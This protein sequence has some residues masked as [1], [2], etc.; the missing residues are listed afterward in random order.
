MIK[1]ISLNIKYFLNYILKYNLIYF[2]YVYKLK[3]LKKLSNIELDN[4]KIKKIKKLLYKSKKSK[5]YSK[6][7]SHIDIDSI[8][9]LNDL[10][11]LPIVT[12]EMIKGKEESLLT[13]PK[14]FLFKGF[15][16]GSTGSPL[17]VY[18]D[19]LSV[20]RENATVWLYR[21]EKGLKFKQPV[22]SLRGNLKKGEVFSFDRFTNTLYLSSYELN[23]KN[24]KLYYELINSFKPKAILAYPS[25]IY[26]LVTLLKE[27]SYEINVDLVFTSSETLYSY[28]RFFVEKNLSTTIYD[29]Y[30]NAERTVAFQQ[31]KNGYY[32]EPVCYSYCEFEKNRLITTSLNNFSFPLIR[33]KVDDIIEV[34]NLSEITQIIGREDDVVELQDGTKIGRLDHIFKGVDGIKY[35]QIIQNNLHYIDINIVEN[36]FNNDSLALLETKIQERLG[37]G[38]EYNIKM[39]NE[40]EIKYMK[41]GKFKMVINN[42]QK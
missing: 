22:V 29:W 8:H 33:Y 39:I 30:G 15:T 14:L 25:S 42:V 40:D 26:L 18:Y 1:N 27:N 23:K 4:K 12:K 7:Y 19:Y 20:L 36:G 2:Y 11:K 5:F 41:S 28:Q 35:A 21:E 17:T 3:R 34:N 31:L 6:L 24:I 38:I 16:S 13:I 37:N 10:K 32:E 9:T